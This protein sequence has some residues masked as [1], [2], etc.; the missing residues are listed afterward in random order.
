MRA[1]RNADL[2][3][4]RRVCGLCL[5]KVS[6]VE[7]ADCYA[8]VEAEM[9]ALEEVIRAEL[10]SDSAALREL[11]R[12]TSRYSGKR[13]R[14]ALVF[15]A[16]KAAG[17]EVTPEHQKL[18]IIV[19]LIHTA[20]LIHD[21]ILDH[22]DMR[23]K[24]PT[25]N[26]LHGN[27]VAVLLGDFIHAHAFAMSV[28]LPTP[29]ASRLLARVVKVVCNGEIQQIFDRFDFTLGETPYLKIIE[30]KTAELYAASTELGAIYAGASEADTR[31]LS[32]YGRNI[33]VAFQVI[34]DCLD[35]TGDESVVGKSL[36]T[37]IDTGKLTL[38]IIRLRD[39]SGEADRNRLLSIIQDDGI[40]NRRA[41]LMEEFDLAAALDYSFQR[42]D[43]F[44]RAA[45]ES[46][47]TLPPSPARESLRSVAEF[48]L[49]RKR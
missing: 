8:P 41:R 32:E 25:V 28:E 48:V 22:A 44:I 1:I 4:W 11:V 43:D 23:R 9:R 3:V 5:E 12:H 30:A 18:A 10:A 21:D 40:E 13:L 26:A 46:L 2:V 31:A 6:V 16:A 17:R 19:E 42:A 29:D 24:V 39:Q 20:T 34:D 27:H 33:G 49:C 7:L 35:L 36:G 14:P 45:M 37:D 47:E 15:L 38:P